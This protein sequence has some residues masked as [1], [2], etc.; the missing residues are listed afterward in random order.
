MRCKLFVD[1]TTASCDEF[2]QWLRLQSNSNPLESPFFQKGEFL[3]QEIDPS[4]EKHAL[5]PSA[6]LRI[7]PAR[8][9][10]ISCTTCSSLC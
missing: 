8:A 5:S 9:E 7:G 3:L 10:T 2:E 6:W 4:L 1:E